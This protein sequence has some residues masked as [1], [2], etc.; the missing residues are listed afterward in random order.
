MS[1][2]WV[3][4]VLLLAGVVSAQTPAVDPKPGPAIELGL[5][6]GYAAP[7]GNGEQDT[8]MVNLTFGHI[9]LQLDLGYR[10]GPRW[11]AGAYAQYG[12]V[13]IKGCGADE[14]CSG[15]DLRFGLQGQYHFAPAASF[16]PWLGLGAGY[17]VFHAA[18]SAS[19]GNLSTDSKGFE[20]ANLSGGAS[21]KVSDSFALGPLAS[22]TLGEYSKVGD[23]AI[24]DKAMHLWLFGGL[25]GVFDV[26]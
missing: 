20:L 17:E 24:P 12:Q 6:L 19:G 9:P 18:A 21:F 22:L 4:S 3:I 7:L 25:R 1:R 8:A 16:D 10:F 15:Y 2:R 14:S 11:F 5:R 13:F 26:R 23:R